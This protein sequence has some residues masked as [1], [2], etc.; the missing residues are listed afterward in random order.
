[1]FYYLEYIMRTRLF[2]SR[3]TTRRLSLCSL[4]AFSSQT[5]ED[6]FLRLNMPRAFDV[7]AE[8]MKSSY[9]RLMKKLH[10][11]RHTLKP[12]AEQEDISQAASKVTHAYQ[13]LKLPHKRSVHM[14]DLLDSPLTEDCSGDLVGFDFLKTVM[15]LRE[16]IFDAGEVEDKALIND[17]YKENQARIESICAELATAF[18]TEDI[19]TAQKLTAQL[20]YWNRIDE[21]LR[22]LL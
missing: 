17:L 12:I 10:P 11:D 4:R 1:M 2:I 18:K 9:M 3:Q 15:E 16:K 13:V 14:L 21:S 8:D 19:P 20:Q 7:S 6:Y 22:H 5:K